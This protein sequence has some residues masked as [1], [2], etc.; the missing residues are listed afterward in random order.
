ML[1][2]GTWRPN[3]HRTA[4]VGR[5]VLQVACHQRLQACPEGNLQEYRVV[6]VGRG[7]VRPGQGGDVFLELQNCEE[8]VLPRLSYSKPWSG[9]D[10]SVFQFNTVVERKPQT[11]RRERIN[12]A[13]RWSKG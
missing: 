4:A 12:K 7:V 10:F 1:P 8:G 13:S 11:A 3:R 6:R 5:K 2:G 9:Q